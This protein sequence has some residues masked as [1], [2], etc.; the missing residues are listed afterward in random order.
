MSIDD[1]QL[2]DLVV[3]I[4]IMWAVFFPALIWVINRHLKQGDARDKMV[5]EFM[6]VANETFKRL[7]VIT[8]VQESRLDR[9][10]EDIKST[11][12]IKYNKGK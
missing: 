4:I 7:E 1:I 5:N 6:S 8:G 9:V 12:M 11:F 10:E 2:R 3:T